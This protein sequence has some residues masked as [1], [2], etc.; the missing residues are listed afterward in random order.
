MKKHLVLL[1]T[2]ICIGLSTITN[3]QNEHPIWCQYSVEVEHQYLWEYE[4]RLKEFKATSESIQ[5][6]F[7][8]EVWTDEFNYYYFWKQKDYN[9]L[10]TKLAEIARLM[11]D[12]DYKK[13]QA[14]RKCRTSK[15]QFLRYIPELSYVVSHSNK[16]NDSRYKIWDMLYLKGDKEDEFKKLTTQFKQLLHKHEHKNNFHIF[17]GDIGYD[18]PLYIIEL[19]AHDAPT[20]WEQDQKLW[21]ALGEDG[22]NIYKKMLSLLKNRTIKHFWYR[23]DLSYIMKDEALIS[24]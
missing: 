22:R 10:E 11:K 2:T 15:I 19:Q 17:K 21:L 4:S 9:E 18:H 1:L 13:H 8:Y 12:W 23:P 5:F 20:L 24:E 16:S 3:A 6:P 7:S 14:H